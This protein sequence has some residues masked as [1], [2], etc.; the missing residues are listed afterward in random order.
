MLLLKGGFFFKKKKKSSLFITP[1]NSDDFS[2]KSKLTIISLLAWEEKPL[3][4]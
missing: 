3:S 4:K 2:L 1:V